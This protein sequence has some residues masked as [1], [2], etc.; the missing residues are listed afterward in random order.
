M[1]ER[2]YPAEFEAWW[3]T[4][5]HKNRDL[6][7]Y[8]VKKQIAFDA[9]CFAMQPPSEPVIQTRNEEAGFVEF[10]NEDRPYIVR[11]IP[12]PAAI[13]LDMETRHVIGYRVYDPESLPKTETD[14]PSL[15]DYLIQACIDYRLKY[16]S[17]SGEPVGIIPDLPP[18][19]K[20]IEKEPDGW[21]IVPRDPTVDMIEAAIGCDWRRGYDTI[22]NIWRSI[23][24]KSPKP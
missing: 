6:A 2:D 17:G 23:L 19:Q 10:A 20:F 13:L 9:F 21:Q 12:A 14:K 5:W 4:Y 8:V 15:R 7:D 18:L 22:R 3:K 24:A 11:H 1:V 16:G